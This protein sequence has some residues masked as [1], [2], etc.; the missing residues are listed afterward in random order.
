MASPATNSLTYNG[1][2]EAV[3]TLAV[4]QTQ[5]IDG[6]VQG[7]DAPFN[8]LVP[9]MLDYAELRIS[10]DLDLISQ[11]NSN[12]YS[13]IIGNNYLTIPTGD[14]VTIQTMEIANSGVS[15]PLLPVSKE[16]IQNIYGSGGT[17]G[18]PQ[19]FAPY[20]GDRATAGQTSNLFI[21]GPY[22]DQNYSV[23]VTGT[24]RMP[25]LYQSA[26]PMDAATGTTFISV[27]LPDLL[28][29]A[30]MIF[31]SLYQRNFSATS[32]DPEMPGSYELQYGNLLKGALV[33]ESRKRLQAAAWTA[34]APAPVATPNRGQ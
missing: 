5:T 30:S 32:N 13:L 31:I 22:P 3:A 20:G 11:Q 12:S 7:V 18:L 9:S 14:F 26:N 4:L 15:Q 23:L 16:Y 25:S 19:Y 24:M 17:Q 1:Y 2:I 27:W 8:E 10:R 33:E 21:L 34:Y 28:I 29:T 6:V